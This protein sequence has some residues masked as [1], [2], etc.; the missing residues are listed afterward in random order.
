[1]ALYNG[2]STVNRNKHF[3]IT[4]FELV[5]QDLNNNFNIRKGEKLMNPEYGTV[6]WDMIFEPLDDTTRN[7]IMQDVKRIISL[8][9]RVGAQNVVI[10]QYDRGIQI[11][12]DLIYI[13]TNQ[14]SLL[15]LQFDQS[16]KTSGRPAA[17]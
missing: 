1:M 12:I 13:S 11:E 9:P 10:T 2:F 17:L 14:R 7:I 8:D 4:D 3:R 16:N 15:N 6:I 5:K